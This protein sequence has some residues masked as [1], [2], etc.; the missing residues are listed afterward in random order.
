MIKRG[1]A[2][3]LIVILLFTCTLA[4]VTSVTIVTLQAVWDFIGINNTNK[5][6]IDA[7]TCTIAYTK[8]KFASVNRQLLASLI[9]ICLACLFSILMLVVLIMFVTGYF[10]EK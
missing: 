1:P 6:L 7:T 10:L 4:V 3:P 9:G 8:W 5:I 2:K